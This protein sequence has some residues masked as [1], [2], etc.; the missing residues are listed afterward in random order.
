LVEFSDDL[1]L[2]INA[3]SFCISGGI[4]DSLVVARKSARE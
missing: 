4:L 3:G 1:I 2:A